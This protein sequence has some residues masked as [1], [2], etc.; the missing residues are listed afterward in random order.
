MQAN[1][2]KCNQALER[3]V[4]YLLCIYFYILN[5]YEMSNTGFYLYHQVKIQNQEYKNN[6][7]FHIKE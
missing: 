5:F 2:K 1:D 4:I 3:K 7:F 6:K